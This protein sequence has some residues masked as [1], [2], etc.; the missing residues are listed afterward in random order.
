MSGLCKA[1]DNHVFEYGHR[2]AADQTRTSLKKIV[3]YVGTNYGQDTSHDRETVVRIDRTIMPR[4]YERSSEILELKITG[5]AECFKV[6]IKSST[7]DALRDDTNDQALAHGGGAA[8][9]I[10]NSRHG[11][12]TSAIDNDSPIP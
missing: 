2:T 11:S 3:Q 8:E 5:D 12:L 10:S 7:A 9:I 6:T 4:A 1:L